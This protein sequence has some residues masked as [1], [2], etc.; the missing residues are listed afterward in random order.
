MDPR[1]K[2]LIIEHPVRG[3]Y[4]LIDTA[5]PMETARDVYRFEVKVPANGNVG[6]PVTEENVYDQQTAVSQY[7]PGLAAGLHP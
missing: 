7:E 6:F 1:A 4:N 5:K 2:T 3:G